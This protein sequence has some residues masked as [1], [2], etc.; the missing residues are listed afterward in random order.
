MI[1]DRKSK[2]SSFVKRIVSV[3]CLKVYCI[4]MSHASSITLNFITTALTFFKD[5]Q[6]CALRR[7][8]QFIT[9]RPKNQES[10]EHTVLRRCRGFH[11]LLFFLQ[12]HLTVKKRLS[13]YN[14]AMTLRALTSAPGCSHTI[15][16]PIAAASST[17]L[18]LTDGGV[19]IETH[20]SLRLFSGTS[21][22]LFRAGKP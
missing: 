16:A 6:V 7:T 9:C 14:E 11:I 19:I 15:L 4:T 10:Q 18:T 13:V 8:I 12:L 5:T 20:K 1:Y 17:A 21:K 3:P 22:R 2:D